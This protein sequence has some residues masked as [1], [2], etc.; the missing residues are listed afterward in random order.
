[1]RNDAV[2]YTVSIFGTFCV[3]I[4]FF[5]SK[6]EDDTRTAA[7]WTIALMFDV[8]ANRASALQV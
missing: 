6:V 2:R 5:L 8:E 4:V 7:A 1:V 3:L